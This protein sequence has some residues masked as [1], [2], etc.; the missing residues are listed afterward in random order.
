MGSLYT[1]RFDHFVR[2]NR[3][4]VLLIFSATPDLNLE[5]FATAVEHDIEENLV[6]DEILI[7]VREP[8]LQ[9][10]VNELQRDSVC[11]ATLRRLEGRTSVNIVG[12]DHRG[13]EKTRLHISGPEAPNKVRFSDF[14][15][16]AVTSIFNTRHGFVEANE[17]YHFENPSGRH[18]ERFIRLSNI[19]ARG[20]EI[21]FIGFCV[22]PYVPEEAKRAYLDTPSL[23]AIIAAINE[24]R[25]AFAQVPAIL[26]D[27]FSSYGGLTSFD[28]DQIEDAF[29]L[30]SASSSGSLARNL[31]KDFRLEGAQIAHLLFLGE[32]KSNS[33]IVCDLKFHQE[34]NPDGISHPPAVEAATSCRMCAQGSVAIKLQGD[35]FEFAGPQQSPL[36][37][38]K[39]D[40]PKELPALMDRLA[41]QK[42]FSVGLA[43]NSSSFKRLMEIAPNA[44]LGSA[45][46]QERLDYALRRSL[47]SSVKYIIALD[48]DSRPFADRINAEVN[49]S[50]EVI[51]RKNL[52]LIADTTEDAIC[53]AAA[54]IESGRSLLD[55]SRDLR[56]IAPNAPLLYLVAFSKTSGELRRED[57]KK[58]LVQTFN[59]FPYELVEVERMVLPTSLEPN[60]WQAELNLLIKPDVS[61]LVPADLKQI[62][63]ERIQRLRKASTPLIN[64]L[65][66]ENKK[67]RA[68][69]LQPGFVFWPD[70][71][72]TR[73][74]A[75]AD[76]FY[77]VAS[78]LQQLR[79]NSQKIGSK[80]AIRSNW[81]Q[82]TLLAPSNFGRFNDDII[83]ASI[84]RAANTIEMN[85]ADSPTESR[86]ISRL[87][88]RTIEA[89]HTP[90]GGA[91]SE[92]LLALATQ[93]LRLCRD[94]FAAIIKAN[95]KDAPMVR[96]LQTV[97]SQPN[98]SLR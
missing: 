78:V 59:P 2:K 53:I 12:Y 31:C 55:V 30:I 77:T 25:S 94:D 21:S 58:H 22:L 16:R 29:V 95:A 19:L 49:N 96:F 37:I 40:G 63:Q 9:K 42:I 15:R 20:A 67:G 89:A 6:P 66:I 64:D 81:F 73:T 74:H 65:F 28:F 43:G 38:G 35:Q 46:F 5:S 61:A 56:N 3:R 57:L 32:D 92:F 69:S 91:A 60:A 45:K 18:T 62:V 41:G 90:R 75:Q 93:R 70:G 14:R 85:Y 39:N 36:L 98:A 86:E 50:A 51:D 76:V 68:L 72:P 24:H 13:S 79:A 80:A 8:S 83:Q 11:I 82:Q 97:C 71:L 10:T 27:N 52:D 47:P 87:I 54:V 44:L 33:N 88:I 4:D 34:E 23:Y 1:F 26:A 17:T 7:V 48:N 84:L